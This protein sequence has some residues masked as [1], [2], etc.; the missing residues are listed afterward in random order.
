MDVA[1]SWSDIMAGR[2]LSVHRYKRETPKR[3]ACERTVGSQW[4]LM[5]CPFPLSS[6]NFGIEARG[7]VAGV[8]A[9]CAEVLASP[10]NPAAAQLP[11]QLLHQPPAFGKL[12]ATSH[13]RDFYPAVKFG[14][15]WPMVCYYGGSDKQW[16]R[17]CGLICLVSFGNQAKN[18][19]LMNSA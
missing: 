19:R 1:A 10:R 14:W 11:L 18:N 12:T 6:H 2:F 5:A 16:D 8:C 13:P 15:N 3:K 17:Q 4:L 9:G 7:A